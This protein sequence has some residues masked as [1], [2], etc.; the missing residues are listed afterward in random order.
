LLRYTPQNTRND[1][2]GS[3]LVLLYRTLLEPLHVTSSAL[4]LRKA[5]LRRI[6][7]LHQ[8][9]SNKRRFSRKEPRSK[10]QENSTRNKKFATQ[11]LQ[12]LTTDHSQLLQSSRYI[13]LRYTP[14]NT[15]ND[16]EGSGL[17]L[18]YRTLL[19]PL[20]VTSSALK[21]RTA[22]LRRIEKLHQR[23]SNKR[24]FSR[25]EARSKKQE[26]PKTN[27]K[28]TT[29]HLQQLTTDHAQLLQSSR[30]ILLRY[31]P[32]NTRN[33][34]EGSGLVLPYRTLLETLHV[35][36]SALKLRTAVLRRIEKLHQR[37]GNK[38]RFSRKEARSKNQEIPKTNNKQTTQHL[39]QLTTDHSQLLQSSRYI[40]LHCITQNTRNDG[41]E[42]S[43]LVPL[44]TLQEPLV[45][46][47]SGL[48]PRLAV[49][50]RIEKLH[51]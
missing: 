16:G 28:Q 51:Q 9:G 17:V 37:G 38:R 32:Q 23:G 36:S 19:E 49:L 7:K 43:I 31:T 33:D 1:G 26:I 11:H 40:L 14:Q 44:R 2:E 47:S 4:K 21:L 45:V 34:G 5:V 13:L 20:H 30:Y 46:T 22:V 39:Q 12:Q 35:T 50:R 25:K 42:R 8:R 6:E 15:R 27:N 48:K 41:E 29:Q 24:R 10:N 3:G 18:P